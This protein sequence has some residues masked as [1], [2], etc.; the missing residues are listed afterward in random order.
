[1][2]GAENNIVLGLQ[3]GNEG[4]ERIIDFLANRSD[5]TVRFQGCS[6]G[7]RTVNAGGERYRLRY[8][9]SGI[10]HDGKKCLISS[11]VSIDLEKF[12]RE[13]ALVKEAGILKAQLMISPSCSLILD[14]HKTL[15]VLDGR[16]FGHGGSGTMDELGLG[17]A[18]ADKYRML[19]IMTGDLRSPPVLKKKIQR[20]VTVKNEYLTKIYGEKPL[21]ADAI[22]EKCMA[23]GEA[24]LPYI[25]DVTSIVEKAVSKNMGILFEGCDGTLN[26]IDRGMYPCVMPKTAITAAALA[27]TGLKWNSPMRVI[28]VAKAY[29]TRTDDGPFVTEELGA[30]ASFIRN[31]GKEFSEITREPRRTGW[32][33]LP[34]LKYAVRENGVHELAVTKLDVLTGIDELKICVAYMVDGVERTSFDLT[35][36][37]MSR[38]TPVYKI[39]EGWN[40][41]L[42]PCGDFN[43]MP[44]QA[45][46]YIKYIEEA[47]GVPVIW[48]GIGAEWGSALFRIK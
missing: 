17:H 36:D 10:H 32:L 18:C 23:E 7:G 19:G 8:L 37:E 11:G 24:I 15:D 48:V 26:D 22:F 2:T 29:C 12:S 35:A 38:A 3:W 43:T 5:V 25:G 30:V 40:G 20:N 6:N 47:T 21:N 41:D 16:V 34:A 14:Y 45:Q 42:P 46:T 1:M 28:G 39:I 31:R 33:D 9:P 44:Y 4:K 27:G 13:L